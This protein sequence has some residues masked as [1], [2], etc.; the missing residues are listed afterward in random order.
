MPARGVTA[1]DFERVG[2]RAGRG[3]YIYGARSVAEKSF[4]ARI[5]AVRI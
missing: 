4:E 5:R 1:C 3:L 2:A